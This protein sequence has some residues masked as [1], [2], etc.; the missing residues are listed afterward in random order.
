MTCSY[1]GTNGYEAFKVW[2]G[3]RTESENTMGGKKAKHDKNNLFNLD[4]Y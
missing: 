4:N 3:E 1:E 2:K